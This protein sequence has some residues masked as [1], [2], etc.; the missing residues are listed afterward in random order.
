MEAKQTAEMQIAAVQDVECT[1]LESDMVQHQH[2]VHTSVGNVDE[3][4][5]ATAKIQQGVHL[6]GAARLLMGCPGT[7]RKTDIDCGRVQRVDG[8]AKLN[9]EW[10]ISV[11]RASD[12][13]QDLRQ[14]GI[15]TPVPVLV[16]VCQSRA[17]HLA[18][19]AKMIELAG[20]R[21]QA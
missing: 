8:I 19:N 2:I 15:H 4:R 5:N 3:G 10:I 9:T 12:T 6:N 18:A 11:E 14:I 21:I 1:W 17:R 7:E 20:D 16:G 13:D